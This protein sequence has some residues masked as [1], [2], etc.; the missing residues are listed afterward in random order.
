[1]SPD[2]EYP[3]TCF[4]GGLAA[5][6]TD[7]VWL[8]GCACVGLVADDGVTVLTNPDNRS[9]V[10]NPS[11]RALTRTIT[12]RTMT[13]TVPVRNQPFGAFGMRGYSSE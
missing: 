1:L 9:H 5:H 4:K 10:A 6:L 12:A 7:G 8:P 3:P 2:D 11:R 13:S